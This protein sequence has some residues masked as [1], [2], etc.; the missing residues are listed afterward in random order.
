MR[1]NVSK[2]FILLAAACAA[3]AFSTDAAAAQR[4]R[5]PRA[6]GYT[7]DEVNA[8]IR[9]VET[10]M[11]EFVRLFAKSLDRS[12]LDGTRREDNLNDRAKELERATDELRRE[13]DRKESYVAT[14]PEVGRCLNIAGEID[15]TV[16][17]RRLGGQTERQ[18]ALLRAELNELARVYNLPRVR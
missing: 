5:T 15:R 10:R 18:W 13:F 11:D 9:R 3:F 14:R 4:Y 17:R 8:M 16:R 1:K 6:R 12:G 7:R 2:I